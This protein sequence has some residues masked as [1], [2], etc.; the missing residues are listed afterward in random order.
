[1]DTELAIG[2]HVLITGE[3]LDLMGYSAHERT[4]FAKPLIVY[5]FSDGK[6]W[7]SVDGTEN[8]SGVSMAASSFR[9]ANQALVY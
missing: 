4:I 3:M 2:D 7:A 9:K 6:V 8:T 5:K 1:M